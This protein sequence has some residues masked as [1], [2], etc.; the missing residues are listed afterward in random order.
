VKAPR[1]TDLVKACLE[2]LRLRGVM[3]WRQNSGAV[4]GKHRGKRRFVR[5]NTAR[6]CSDVLGILPG[7]RFLAVEAKLPGRKVTA[8]QQGFLDAVRA[9]GGL[10]LVVTDVAELVAALDALGGAR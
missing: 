6:G 2:Y 8:D 10:A 7:G 1:E 5:F 4:T 9:A 3:C